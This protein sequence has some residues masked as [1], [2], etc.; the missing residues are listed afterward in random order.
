MKQ[1]VGW[2]T[3]ALLS[4][5]QACASATVT[6]GPATAHPN[7]VLLHFTRSLS[8]DEEVFWKTNYFNR[9]IKSA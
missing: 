8:A 4:H 3:A 9:E 7:I 1:N 2:I 6:Q 5:S